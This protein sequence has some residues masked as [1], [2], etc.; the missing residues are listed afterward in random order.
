V[1]LQVLADPEEYVT[2]DG[3]LDAAGKTVRAADG[4]A[5]RVFGVAKV[6]GGR[7]E[8]KFG[9]DPPAGGPAGGQFHL[10]MRA[11]RVVLTGGAGS[12][13]EHEITLLDDQ[14]SAL[15]P[16]S[17]GVRVAAAAAEFTLVSEPAAGRDLAKLVCTVSRSVTLDV[18]FILRDVPVP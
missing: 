7:V 16:V 12:M 18:P 6:A 4:G 15:T 11:G 17:A 14:G 9:I 3:I 10:T 8:V 5:L 13:A 2:V 1:A